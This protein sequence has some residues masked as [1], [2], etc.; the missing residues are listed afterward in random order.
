[1]VQDSNPGSQPGASPRLPLPLIGALVVVIAVGL[2]LVVVALSSGGGDGSGN[3]VTTTG[4][5]HDFAGLAAGTA[6]P[7]PQATL[8]LARATALAPN[9]TAIGEGDRLVIE[10]YGIN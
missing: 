2:V 1:M 6:V 7:A 10:K 5:D 3:S 9:L 4:N 8:D